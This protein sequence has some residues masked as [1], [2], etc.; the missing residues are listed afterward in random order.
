MP[1]EERLTVPAHVGDNVVQRARAADDDVDGARAAVN[2]DV[3]RRA[4]RHRLWLERHNAGGL[5]AENGRQPSSGRRRVVHHGAVVQKRKP[6]P[7]HRRRLRRQVV[8]AACCAGTRGAAVRAQWRQGVALRPVFPRYGDAAKR[9]RVERNIVEIERASGRHCQ[10]LQQPFCREG[11]SR[12]S[13]RDTGCVVRQRLTKATY[14]PHRSLTNATHKGF[15]QGRKRLS[16]ATH[17]G[18]TIQWSVR[19]SAPQSAAV[20]PSRARCHTSL[21]RLAGDPGNLQL[22]SLQRCHAP[23]ACAARP[24]EHLAR[25]ADK[26]LQLR[27]PAGRRKHRHEALRR[28]EVD[29]PRQSELRGSAAAA[30]AARQ[31]R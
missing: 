4:Q 15:S 24:L 27:R 9:D 10:H 20:C 31:R 26:L 2:R 23:A 22:A 21:A 30:R 3:V 14:G 7:H 25:E 16:K 18:H 28:R 12:C 29:A 11:S 8:V 19:G 13:A 17:K 6:R 5:R 1:P